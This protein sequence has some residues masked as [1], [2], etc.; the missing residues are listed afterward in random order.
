MEQKFWRKVFESPNPHFHLIRKAS[1]RPYRSLQGL[2]TATKY[3][4]F[5]RFCP[6]L[7]NH[8]LPTGTGNDLQARERCRKCWKVAWKQQQQH[9]SAVAKPDILGQWTKVA[10][11]FLIGKYQKS[12]NDLWRKSS[13]WAFK[14]H[15][16]GPKWPIWISFPSVVNLKIHYIG[17][18]WPTWISFLS[19]VN[20]KIHYIGPKWLW[21]M[22]NFKIHYARPK[23]PIWICSGHGK[24]K[25]LYVGPK[26][27]TNF[28][29]WKK[30]VRGLANFQI[31]FCW[32]KVDNQFLEFQ[33]RKF[34]IPPPPPPLP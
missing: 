22:V 21:N 1:S 15:Y 2:K 23:W 4:V 31:L 32:T 18:K 12:C 34:Q 16:V 25:I 33:V 13:F 7:S 27:P 9:A 11:Q 14:I 17:P 26:W 5:L 6:S 19:M 24:F 10:N 30:V 28:W 8:R 29:L 3:Y 20:I